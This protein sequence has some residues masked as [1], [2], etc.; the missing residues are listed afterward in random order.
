MNHREFE[1]W[2]PPIREGEAREGEAPTEPMPF[3]MT[4]SRVRSEAE[5]RIPLVKILPL[6]HDPP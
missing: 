4:L 3:Q 2:F 5:P 6:P 1:S